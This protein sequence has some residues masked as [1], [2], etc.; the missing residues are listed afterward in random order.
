M[1][2]WGKSWGRTW[3]ATAC[4]SLRQLAGAGVLA[5]QRLRGEYRDSLVA[6]GKEKVY[7]SIP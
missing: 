2:A 1:A 5:G 4:Q 3:L 7:G 6:H